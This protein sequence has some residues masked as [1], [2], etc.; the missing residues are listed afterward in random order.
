[1]EK[2]DETHDADGNCQLYDL[3]LQC[4]YG[5][6]DQVRPVI[7]CYDFNPFRQAWYYV[8]LYLLLDPLY[9]IEDVFTEADDN[10]A[11]R[12]LPLSVEIGESPPYFRPQLNARH[13]P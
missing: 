6:L 11:T 1:M 3:F 5:A 8:F 9:D 10:D 13:I 4:V 2:E 7:R 12:N